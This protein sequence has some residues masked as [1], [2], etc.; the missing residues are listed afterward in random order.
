MKIGL[1]AGSFDPVTSGHLD[2][3]RRAAT[4]YDRVVVAVA[5][6]SAKKHMFTQS[7]RVTMLLDALG[8]GDGKATYLAGGQAFDKP[9]DPKFIVTFLPPSRMLA[10]F[11]LKFVGAVA[12]IRG[13]RAM[14]D[15]EAEFQLNMINKKLVPEIDTVFFM[16]SPEQLYTSSSIA[17]EVASIGGDLSHFVPPN[18]ATKLLQAV[19]RA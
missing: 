7:E 1:Y 5:T 2:I 4:Q 17:K 18:V 6:N 19:G 8:E 13:L 11:A 9:Q 16:T 15:F 12:L 3:I 14:S 10:E